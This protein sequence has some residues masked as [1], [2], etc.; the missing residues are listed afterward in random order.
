MAKISDDEVSV[1]PDTPRED[2]SCWSPRLALTLPGYE[3]EPTTSQRPRP[4]V[5]PHLF[6][7]PYIEDMNV[8]EHMDILAEP[9]EE[10]PSRPVSSW[11]T[12]RQAPPTTVVA[13]PETIVP[14]PVVGSGRASGLCVRVDASVMEALMR[15][16]E[17]L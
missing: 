13:V 6:D 9:I 12:K 2:A 15:G 8:I 3:T 7:N 4:S 5:A 16:D 14:K 1:R 11:R 10:P 17:V